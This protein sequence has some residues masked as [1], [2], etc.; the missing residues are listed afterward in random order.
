MA[1]F[2]GKLHR[3][4]AEGAGVGR[5]F[6]SAAL[7]IIVGMMKRTFLRLG[8]FALSLTI[9]VAISLL[10]T[11][12]RSE[13]ATLPP[14]WNRLST[15][16]ASLDELVDK[17]A[18]VVISVP[19]DDEVYIG[20]QKVE[21]SQISTKIRLLLGNVD[22]CDRVVFIKG[23]PNV[24]FQTVDLIVRQAKDADINRIEFV[25]DKKKRGGT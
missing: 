13:E 17:G 3:R 24:K 9:G 1:G 22:F 16:C 14:V 6:F 5:N 4:A 25:L 11:N 19:N 7:S 18:N 21:L 10:L 2:F 8:T 12:H 23:A 15:R 20:K